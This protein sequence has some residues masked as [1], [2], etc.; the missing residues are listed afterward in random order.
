MEIDRALRDSG[1]VFRM[2]VSHGFAI[3]VLRNLLMQDRVPVDLKYCGSME[4]LASLAGGD[5][6]IAGFHAPVGALQSEV[7]AFYSKWLVPGSQTLI[8]LCSRRQGLMTAPGNPLGISSLR[9]LGR[10]GLRF[11]NRQFGSGTRILLELLLAREGIEGTAIAGYESGEFTHSAVA[12]YIASGMADAGF[13]VE[14]AARP[15]G[16]EFLPLATERYFLLC[17]DESLASPFISRVLETLTSPRF[18]IAAGQLPGTDT[19]LAGTV[20][21]I[22]EAFPEIAALA[23]SRRPTAAARAKA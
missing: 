4:A 21:S 9:E 13:G 11:V 22:G 5:C 18:R 15:F 14:A 23:E 16:L 7:L 2:R 17:A 8:T 10:P 12:A 20:L 1:M 19:T 3:D 6:E